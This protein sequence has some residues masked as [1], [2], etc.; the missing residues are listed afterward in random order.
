MKPRLGE[1][2]ISPTRNTTTTT[3]SPT[4]PSRRTAKRLQPTE[5]QR[6]A[7]ESEN[8]ARRLDGLPPL[9]KR[10]RFEAER[11]RLDQIDEDGDEV[12]LLEI[13]ETN[14]TDEETTSC[15]F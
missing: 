14:A 11:I 12:M 15:T 2:N 5:S 8:E 1:N 10:R 6:L 13:G 9:E 4:S 3:T 7:Y